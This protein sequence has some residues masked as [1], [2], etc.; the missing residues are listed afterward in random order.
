ML[1]AVLQAEV[2]ADTEWVTGARRERAPHGGAYRLASAAEGGDRARCR[3]ED[4][5][6]G[7]GP[8]GEP[9]IYT[10]RVVGD[11]VGVV[12]RIA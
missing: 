9:G 8:V 4:R 1:S 10:A 2:A 5:A 6:A 11:T 12:A 7:Q 3:D